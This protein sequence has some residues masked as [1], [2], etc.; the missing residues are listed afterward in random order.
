MSFKTRFDVGIKRF[1]RYFDVDALDFLLES[2]GLLGC[3]HRDSNIHRE[4]R[5]GTLT[6]GGGSV[7]LASWC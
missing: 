2:S 7:Q 4:L 1:Q 6:E 3:M 5:Q